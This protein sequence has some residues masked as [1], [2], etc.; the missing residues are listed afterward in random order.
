MMKVGEIPRKVQEKR[1]RWFGHVMRREEDC[2]GKR[3]MMALEVQG[4]GT[5]QSND[6][7]TKFWRT[8]KRKA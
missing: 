2:V 4:R 3:A 7:W 5:G 1:S 6:E 8:W